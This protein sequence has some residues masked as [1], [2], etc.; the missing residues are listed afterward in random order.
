MAWR[1]LRKE[2]TAEDK[3]WFF[4]S[5]N[6][7]WVGND[8]ELFDEP[9]NMVEII[10]DCKKAMVAT[11]LDIGCFDVRVQTSKKKIPEY[12]LVEVNS[13]PALMEKGIAAYMAQLVK[14]FNYKVK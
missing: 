5:E 2:D 8:H 10:E 13:A 12:I 11:G 9:T 6:C 14:V 1:K 3:R 7:N 4:N